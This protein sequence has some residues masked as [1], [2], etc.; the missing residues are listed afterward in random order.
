MTLRDTLII[1]FVIGSL[2]SPRRAS[3]REGNRRLR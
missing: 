1:E 2:Y 3:V